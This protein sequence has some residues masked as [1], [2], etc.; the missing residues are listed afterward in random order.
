[1][2]DG[3]NAVGNE[4]DNKSDNDPHFHW[5]RS[6]PVGHI[7]TNRIPLTT[8]TT[9]ITLITLIIII[10]NLSFLL[11]AFNGS[12]TY[13]ILMSSLLNLTFIYEMPSIPIYWNSR[14]W[15]TS[16]SILFKF[17]ILDD[18]KS[19][20]CNDPKMDQRSAPMV[21]LSQAGVAKQLGDRDQMQLTPGGKSAECWLG[22]HDAIILYSSWWTSFK[23]VDFLPLPILLQKL[24][25]CKSW[26]GLRAKLGLAVLSGISR[27]FPGQPHSQP[28]FKAVSLYSIHFIPTPKVV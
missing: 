9:L 1:M 8:R 17:H 19:M 11:I 24:G 4:S 28:T 12:P 13:Y 18:R 2:K 23:L 20:V 15:L 16:S 7:A 6:F 26:F 27:R 21:F 3:T 10:I 5:N 22:T 25:S 14:R